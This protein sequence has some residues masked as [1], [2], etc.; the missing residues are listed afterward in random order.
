MSDRRANHAPG[1]APHGGV[2]GRDALSR[3]RFLGGTLGL[4]A[5]TAM[6][7]TAATATT[8]SPARRW[9]AGDFHC[10][11]VFSHDVWSLD[12]LDPEQPLDALEQSYTWGWTAGQQ[13]S[14]A[15]AR[16]LDFLAI[17]DHDRVDA[18]FGD[19]YDSRSLTLIPGYEHSLAGGHVGVFVDDRRRLTDL[20]RDHD[21]STSFSGDAGVE[22]F[23]DQAAQIDALTVLNHPFYGNPGQLAWGYGIPASRGFDA[24]EVWNIHWLARHDVLP[25]AD[26]DNYLSL[27]WW[28]ESF[29]ASTRMPAVGGSD[30]HW[31][32]TTALQGVGQPTTW[33][34]AED[35]SPRAILE[36]VR[37]GRTTISFAPPSHGGPRLDL[38]VA[39]APTGGRSVGIGGQVRGQVPLR[40]HVHVTGGSGH[41]LRLIAT[42]RVVHEQV[43]VGADRSVEVDVV[44]AHRGWLRAEL[45]IDPGYWMSAITS[46]VYAR[47]HHPAGA[48]PTDGPPAAYGQPEAAR[49]SL[50][51]LPG[52]A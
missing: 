32:A 49:L 12:D 36:A 47:G 13:I 11:T 45:L 30:N 50:P 43:L 4:A 21:G 20:V 24:V 27:P 39:E 33:V 29:L 52:A 6:P 44:L 8:G 42:G 17:T 26:S 9:L 38:E 48:E 2:P 51:L 41:R 34:H 23:L 31:R 7:A 40:A 37:E 1:T 16:G 19:D 3:R 35:R 28:E 14:I 25:F 22:R 10:H 15:E 46:P 5:L 18:L